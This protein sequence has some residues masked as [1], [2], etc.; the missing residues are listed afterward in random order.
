VSAVKP[1]DLGPKERRA[2]D[3]WRTIGL[4]EAA[5]MQALRD[6]GLLP[7]SEHDRAMRVYRDLGLSESA[8]E[9]AVAGR[10]GTRRPTSERGSGLQADVDALKHKVTEVA[11]EYQRRGEPELVAY[12]KAARRVLQAMPTGQML[13]M[14]ANVLEGWRPGITAIKGSAGTSRNVTKRPHPNGS[15]RRPATGD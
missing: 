5:A 1:E 3:M 8:A 6:D 13:W 10:D 7:V 15:G 12:E 4:T 11:E 2:F 14:V 9:I